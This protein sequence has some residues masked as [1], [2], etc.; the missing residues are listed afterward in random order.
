MTNNNKP[1]NFGPA[2]QASVDSPP[3]SILQQVADGL[4]AES[5][6]LLI[7]S[8]RDA[9]SC[10]A[11]LSAALATASR[12][13]ATGAESTLS[14]PS[15]SESGQGNCR[16]WAVRQPPGSEAPEMIAD[17]ALELLSQVR[18]AD[19]LSDTLRHRIDR[20]LARL[21]PNGCRG[22]LGTG[23]SD[24]DGLIE[25]PPAQPQ[26]LAAHPPL[27]GPPRGGTGLA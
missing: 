24:H 3:S 17:E 1:T 10:S 21:R 2:I 27:P 6:A 14:S 15:G 23:R 7:T 22:A 9:D 11:V 18:E 19:F 5:K 16:D 4:T 25:G 26:P 20:V 8:L 12:F 13:A